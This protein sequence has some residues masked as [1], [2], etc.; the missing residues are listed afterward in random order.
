V[1]GMSKENVRRLIE[2]KLIDLANKIGSV[3]FPEDGDKLLNETLEVYE[4]I[5]LL[6]KNGCKEIIEIIKP[7]AIAII[8]Y[9]NEKIP[10]LSDNSRERLEEFIETREELRKELGD[11][12]QRI[13]AYKKE[14]SIAY[15]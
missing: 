15:V 2:K 13:K 11:I 4:T 6:N 1:D 3:Y 10:I 5:E 14:S 7:D 12:L 9:W 8:A